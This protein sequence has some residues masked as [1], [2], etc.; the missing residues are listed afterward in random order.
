MNIEIL[1]K[2][3]LRELTATL[4]EL[5]KEMAQM[6]AVLNRGDNITIGSAEIRKR[7]GWSYSAFMSKRHE[8]ARFGMY[9]DGQWRMKTADLKKYIEY[10]K[11]H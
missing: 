6:K 5:S 7:L 4:K 9:N 11:N 8:L 3:D 1:T 2:A 10:K